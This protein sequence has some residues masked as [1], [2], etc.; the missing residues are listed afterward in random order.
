MKTKFA[1]E[2]SEYAHC[3]LNCINSSLTDEEHRQN[4]E[5]LK[6]IEAQVR[7]QND[8]IIFIVTTKNTNPMTDNCASPMSMEDINAIH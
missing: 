1:K 2:K 3:L 8:E 4:I 5:K 7:Q 6:I